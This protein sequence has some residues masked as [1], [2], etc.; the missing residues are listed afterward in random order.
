MIVC[1][2]PVNKHTQIQ[3]YP[4]EVLRLHHPVQLEETRSQC[5]SLRAE[6]FQQNI[7]TSQG[8]RPF[9]SRYMWREST[10]PGSWVSSPPPPPSQNTRFLM[11]KTTS[12]RRF[13][14]EHQLLLH[15]EV[16]LFLLVG[17]TTCVFT[18]IKYLVF[19]C[20]QENNNNKD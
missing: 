12:S 19:S 5:L 8:S 2:C 11:E 6:A 7:E 16:E 18:S 13:L 14:R 20:E 17:S 3:I 9:T 15:R 10:Q 4:P 1:I